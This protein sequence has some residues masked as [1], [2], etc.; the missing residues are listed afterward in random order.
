MNAVSAVDITKVYGTKK[1]P[2]KVLGP[3]SV[4]IP[5]ESFTVILG[6][7]GS[8]KS[9][10]LNLM[11][12]L[13]VPT[14]GKIYIGD[15]VLPKNDN[16][17]A[18]YRSKVGIIFQSY[19]LLPNLTTLQNVM[20]GGWAGNQH[21][22][23]SEAESLLTKLGL[24]HRIKA[25]VTTLSGGERQR[26]AIARSLIG[27]PEILFCDEPTGALDTK[28]ES[29]VIEI[30]KELHDKEGK[31]IIL[32]THN[33]EFQSLATHIITMQDGLLTEFKTV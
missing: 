18:L 10:L 16:K 23:E 12:G 3:L 7:S 30:L 6:R 26:V 4:E 2:L 25:R 14:E 19:N 33:P 32:V 27:N 15:E 5:K 20:M 22:S 24:S 13:D 9:T 1:D 31:T 21:P 8:G 17:R 29:E 28:S 11:A